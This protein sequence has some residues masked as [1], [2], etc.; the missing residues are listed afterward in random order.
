M[1]VSILSSV[2]GRH[3]ADH[4]PG[5]VSGA[6]FYTD[7]EPLIGAGAPDAATAGDGAV[8]LPDGRTLV[9]R[10]YGSPRGVPCVLIPDAA[11]SRL[12]P[13]WLLHDAA[14]P[15]GV[16]LLALDRPAAAAAWPGTGAAA[17]PGAGAAAALGADIA[18][19]VQTLA[20]G[21]V[22]VIG[23]GR[24]ADAAVAMALTQPAVV[25]S[26]IAVS[27]R[28]VP[29]GQPHRHWG[30]GGH[31][32]SRSRRQA[33]AETPLAHWVRTVGRHR[34]DSERGWRRALDSMS[35]YARRALGTRWLDADFRAAVAADV[36]LADATDPAPPGRIAWA[37]DDLGLWEL[38]AVEP[39]DPTDPDPQR[40]EARQPE[41]QQP[42]PPVR[43]WFGAEDP[44]EQVAAGVRSA[45]H[46]PGWQVS[47]VERASVLL[48]AWPQILLTARTAY[49][50]PR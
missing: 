28:P 8:R 17:T 20:V 22:A 27:P 29:T 30:R 36:A 2:T 10:E 35:P 12:A 4:A 48:D 46:R 40:P 19:L 44:R 39:A 18:H 23:L 11:S 9:W 47:T 6:G 32:G 24:G 37:R 43:L 21:T 7:V 34:L 15:E 26:V 42:G 33:H 13:R 41:P 49:L 50:D 1:S 16:R 38:A 14:C 31:C 45:E 25:S 3:R 5:S